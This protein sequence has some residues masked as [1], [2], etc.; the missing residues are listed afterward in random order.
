MVTHGRWSW[1]IGPQI[2]AY[3]LI[4]FALAAPVYALELS[5]G[6]V[7]LGDAFGVVARVA[8]VFAVALLAGTLVPYS[9]DQGL[10]VTAA[11]FLAAIAIIL[12]SLLTAWVGSVT[13]TAAAGLTEVILAGLFLILQ[14]M[15]AASQENNATRYV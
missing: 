13:D 12:C 4:G 11:G 8:L 7:E 2:A 1:W 9:E 6:T 10:S 5:L 15:T 14:A 3:A